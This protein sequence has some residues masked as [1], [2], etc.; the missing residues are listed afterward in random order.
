VLLQELGSGVHFSRCS[1][2]D[3]AGSEVTI[4]QRFNTGHVAFDRCTF[5]APVRPAIAPHLLDAHAVGNGHLDLEIH[6]AELRDNAGTALEAAASG[7][8]T[9][10]LTLTDI[11]GQRLGTGGVVLRAAGNAQASLIM[12]R[13]HMTAPAA[14]ALVDVTA[15]GSSAACVDLAANTLFAGGAAIHL[16]AVPPAALRAVSSADSPAVLGN[17]LA[18]AN[19]GTNSAIQV[20][21][22]A[23]TIV[24]TCR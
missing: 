19:G 18:A 16:T 23:L 17:A 8:A 11:T 20:P 2:A 5:A 14:P 10:F 9:L 13:V 24:K 4:E 22:V 15:E 1:F 7:S 21:P 3:N 6:N 12:A